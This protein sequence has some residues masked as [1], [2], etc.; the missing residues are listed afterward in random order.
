MSS[1][2]TTAGRRLIRRATSRVPY[3]AEWL[4]ARRLLALTGDFTAD[5]LFTA[6]DIDA[7]SAQVRA[8][9]NAV[10]FDLNADT[11][12][13]Q[14]DRRVWVEQIVG[15]KFGDAD[16]D[17][18]VDSA[19]GAI[20]QAN[21][22]QSN[23]GWAG[24]D[25][26][27]SGRVD[28]GDLSL[29]APNN[30]QSVIGGPLLANNAARLST[31]LIDVNGAIDDW[32]RLFN[33]TPIA[34][35][36]LPGVDDALA[37]VVGLV[38]ATANAAPTFNNPAGVVGT[39]QSRL[40]ALGFT[41]ITLPSTAGQSDIT[42]RLQKNFT[43]LTGARE[44]DDGTN[45]L[46]NGLSSALNLNGSIAHSVDFAVSMMLGVDAA[47]FYLRGD[48]T[49]TATVRG[50]GAV[51]GSYALPIATLGLNLAGTLDA[52]YTV[53]FTAGTPTAKIR[54]AQLVSNAWSR[55]QSGQGV[56]DLDLSLTRAGEPTTLAFDGTWSI[57]ITASAIGPATGG[58]VAP[59]LNEFVH[60]V[61]VL[62]DDGVSNLLPASLGTSLNGVRLPF[63]QG[64]PLASEFSEGA[65]RDDESPTWWDG[66]IESIRN[67]FAVPR[68][69]DYQGASFTS[70][71]TV[72]KVDKLRER[73]G[74]TGA[75]QKIGVISNGAVAIA[76]A[77][78]AKDL[79]S[80]VNVAPGFNLQGN[81]GIA[82]L[83]IV[84][85]LAPAAELYFGG[86]SGQASG[87]VA[88]HIAIAEWM[89]A[90]GVT[91]IV[92]DMGYFGEPFFQD[93]FLGATYAGLMNANPG[94]VFV[95]SAGNDALV[96]HQDTFSGAPLILQPSAATDPVTGV[97]LFPGAT[98]SAHRFQ[99]PALGAVPLVPINIP[100]GQTV[101]YLQWSDPIGAP[102]AGNAIVPYLVNP[103]TMQILAVGTPVPGRAEV[104]F[105]FNAAAAMQV[106]LVIVNSGGAI[107]P[108]VQF[109]MFL[110][111]A[112]RPG[113]GVHV[114]NGTG[115]NVAK[116]GDAVFSQ[117]GIDNVIATA[118]VRNG[119]LTQP[120]SYT[121]D[122]PTTVRNG[123]G[124]TT[125]SSVD[126]A[127]VDGIRV[128]G[129][130]GFSTPF[131]GTSSTSPQI[132][133]IV[134][135]LRE[136]KPTATRAELIQAIARG[137]SLFPVRNERLGMGLINAEVSGVFLAPAGSP[138]TL[139]SDGPE[140]ADGPVRG[141]DFLAARGIT[142]EQAPTVS[143]VLQLIAGQAPAGDF[144]RVRFD[145]ITSPT[146]T[147]LTADFGF[148]PASIAPGL[149]ISGA[150]HATMSP[151]ANLSLGI[152]AQG[153][154]L[155]GTSTFGATIAGTIDAT[156]SAGPFAIGA[157]GT[158]GLSPTIGFSTLGAGKLRLGAL[159]N[160]LNLSLQLGTVS[161]SFT[162]D[163]QLNHLDYVD[164]NPTI[165][166]GSHGGDPFVFRAT[167]GLTATQQNG[168]DFNYTF[169]PIRIQNPT[170]NG[171][172]YTYANFL[173]NIYRYGQDQLAGS[174]YLGR[175]LD[176]L[177]Q[178]V[179]P[180][181]D[182]VK[183]GDEIN[184][185]LIQLVLNASNVQ[186]LAP[187]SD[188]A[189]FNDLEA[190]L[191]TGGTSN[192][193]ILRARATI[194]NLDLVEVLTVG[195][196]LG[197]L[198]RNPSQPLNLSNALLNGTM[199]F[200]IDTAGGLFV[201][202]SNKTNLSVSVTATADLGN[203]GLL[204]PYGAGD[205][206][207]LDNGSTLTMNTT[208][209][210]LL[211][212][213]GKVRL[214]DFLAPI[215]N[216]NTSLDPIVVT[217]NSPGA[218]LLP[219]TGSSGYNARVNGITGSAVFNGTGLDLLTLNATSSQWNL[220]NEMRLSTGLATFTWDPQSPASQTLLSVPTST[221]TFPNR[222]GWPTGT[223]SNLQLTGNAITLGTLT[224]AGTDF[225]LGSVLEVRSPAFGLSGV[226]IAIAPSGVT[227][228]G[229]VSVSAASA[230]LF[231]NTSTLALDGLVTV[232]SPTLT[233]NGTGLRFTATNATFKV[234]SL[235]DITATGTLASPIIFNPDATGSARIMSLPSVSVS[236]PKLTIDGRTP[237][238]SFATNGTTPGL[239]L[240]GD[241]KWDVGSIGLGFSGGGTAT[242]GLGA[243]V[244]FE[245]G[246]LRIAFD[247]LPGGGANL[248]AFSAF[249]TGDVD[250]VALNALL[251][252]L[253]GP[254]VSAN[255]SILSPALT[256]GPEADVELKIRVDSLTGGR[257]GLQV[258]SLNVSIANAKVGVLD[259]SGNLG[260]TFSTTTGLPTSVTGGLGFVVGGASKVKKLSDADAAGFDAN[261]QGGASSVSGIEL[262]DGN[263]SFTG[264]VTNGTN[265]DLQVDSTV[266]V[267]FKLADFFDL[268]GVRFGFDFDIAGSTQATTFAPTITGGL[269]SMAVRKVRIK[270]GD[271]LVVTGGSAT[272]DAATLNFTGSGNIATFGPIAA[273]LP[274]IRGSTG[275]GLT[276]TVT[277]LAITQS[278]VPNL[279]PFPGVTDTATIGLTGLGQF[280][281]DNDNAVFSWLPITINALSVKFLPE[282]FSRDAQGNVTGLG[283]PAAFDLGVSGSIG[284]TIDLPGNNDP[285]LPFS[286]GVDG[287]VLDMLALYEIATT[288]STTRTIIKDLQGIS[289]GV[290]PFALLPADQSE[291]IPFTIGGSFGIGKTAN[292][293]FY[294]FVNGEFKYQ[295]F[296]GSV[297]LAISDR[298][299]LLASLSMPLAVPLGPTPFV[300]SGARGAIEWGIGS[301]ATPASPSEMLDSP[302]A[303]P[304]QIDTSNLAAVV[305]AKLASLAPGEFTWDQGVA[306]GLGGTITTAGVPD[307][308]AGNVDLA[309]NIGKPKGTPA[310]QFG[311]GVQVYGQGT[312]DAMGFPLAEAG[313]L[314]DFVNPIEPEVLLA[315]R[316][317]AA[318]NPL[319]F[320][321]PANA[322]FGVH[323]KTEGVVLAPIVA[324][325][326]FISNMT[327]SA[328][329]DLDAI[330]ARLEADR[331]NHAGNDRLLTTIVLDANND[332]TVS[333]AERSTPITR[334]LLVNRALSLLPATLTAAG[335]LSETAVRRAVRAFNG[336]QQ[337]YYA[338][339]ATSGPAFVGNFLQTLANS[340]QLAGLAA[341][342][343][344]NPTLSIRGKIQ[345]VVFGFPV[346]DALAEA[347]I[348]VSKQGVGFDVNANLTALLRK[349]ISQNNPALETMAYALSL[350]LDV[351]GQFGFYRDLTDE[352]SFLVNG[353]LGKK[354][355]PGAT[356][357][358]LG[359]YLVELLNPFDDWSVSFAGQVEFLGFPVGR[360]SGLF[361]GP[362]SQSPVTT[363][364]L[365]GGPG[366]PAKVYVADP[367]G[368]LAI[369]AYKDFT[370]IPV[371]SQSRIDNMAVTGGL[372][373]TGQLLAPA[374]IQ[375]PVGLITLINQQTGWTPP[376][377]TGNIGADVAAYQT[378]INGII[379]GL[380]TSDEF[381]RIQLFIPSPALLFDLDNLKG[382][383]AN[384]LKANYTTDPTID[385]AAGETLTLD[386]NGNGKFDQG[387]TF[388]DRGNGRFDAGE[389]VDIGNGIW[390]PGETLT[391]DRNGNGIFDP[392]DQFDDLN[393]N[394]TREANE[395]FVDLN[396]NGVF[397]AGDAFTDIGD[398]VI[399]PGESF[400]DTNNNG[401]YDPA[402]PFEDLNRNGVRDANEPFDD[403]NRNGVYDATGEPFVD[404]GN[405]VWDGP[406][407][408]ATARLPKQ[409]NA[410]TIST[411][412]AA[413][414]N[415]FFIEGYTDPKLFG[416][417][418]GRGK[419]SVDVTNGLRFQFQQTWLGV[420]VHINAGLGF[421][422]QDTTNL[423]DDLLTSPL[424]APLIG[425]TNVDTVRTFLTNNAASL[426][427]FIAF[428]V[429]F[430]QVD[431][432][433]AGL[434]Q[435]LN[436]VLKLPG[437][438]MSV[439]AAPGATFS[440]GFYTPGFKQPGGTA[441]PI[442]VYGGLSLDA[443]VNL[444]GLLED[445]QASF[446]MTFPAVKA[447]RAL[448]SL[449]DLLSAAVNA[450]PNFSASA[451][452]QRFA[453]S[454]AGATLVKITGASPA[455]P[456][457]FSVQKTGTNF[458]AN[459][460]GRVELLPD[461]SDFALLVNG[462][463]NADL[464]ASTPSFAA[465]LL[466]SAE[467][468]SDFV[469]PSIGLNLPRAGTTFRLVVAS[470]SAKPVLLRVDGELNA[471]GIYVAGQFDL[472]VDAVTTSLA[473]QAN[474]TVRATAG[475]G[476]GAPNLISLT[477][478]AG[479]RI[480][481]NG[482]AARGAM[483]LLAGA[484]PSL[485]LGFGFASNA[486]FE[487]NTFA[488]SQTIN[489]V[490][491]PAGRR[492]VA[493]DTDLQLGPFGFTAGA[494]I[495]VDPTSASLAIT[496]A[497]ENLPVFGT[498]V[499]NG[500]ITVTPTGFATNLS[501][502][503]TPAAGEVF[504][505]GGT[506]TLAVNTLGAVDTFAIAIASPTISLLG[507]DLALPSV[508]ITG[509]LTPTP[510]YTLAI[511]RSNEP[512]N[513]LGGLGI[514]FPS[515]TL[516][517]Y[518]IL[519]DSAGQFRID[520]GANGSYANATFSGWGVGDANVAR[521]SL[522]SVG[523]QVVRQAGTSVIRGRLKGSGMLAL[524]AVNQT[525]SLTSWLSF[526]DDFN[527]AAE[528]TDAA[529]GAN[530]FGIYVD[531]E[532]P[533]FDQLFSGDLW[534]R[535]NIAQS[536][537]EMTALDPFAQPA[538]P[539]RVDVSSTYIGTG[540]WASDSP[541]LGTYDYTGGTTLK[542]A[543]SIPEQNDALK[544][545]A[546][547]L[548]AGQSITVGYTITFPDGPLIY[549]ANRADVASALT[550][551]FSLTSAIPTFNLATI[552]DDRYFEFNEKVL[553]TLTYT[554]VGFSAA[555]LIKTTN[556]VEYT[557]VNA[558]PELDR[559]LAYWEFD[560]GTN[561]TG[562]YTG[563]P[564]F[565]A[566]PNVTVT[567]WRHTS[568]N[569]FTT[570]P[571][572]PGAPGGPKSLDFEASEIDSVTVGD[573]PTFSTSDDITVEAW[574][575]PESLSGIDYFLVAGP[576]AM[577]VNGATNKF[578]V[579]VLPSTGLPSG[580]EFGTATINAWT[581]VAAS[582]NS[583]ALKVYV[584][585]V[586]VIT[587]TL[588]FTQLSTAK[589]V[590]F[591]TDT[592][593]G[594]TTDYYDGRLDEV[595]IWNIERTAIQIAADDTNAISPL[596]SGLVGYWQFDQ[597][598]D[599]IAIYDV[600]G[601]YPAAMRQTGPSFAPALSTTV[602]PITYVGSTP[603]AAG[604]NGGLPQIQP[605]T[606]PQGTDT[607]AVTSTRWG[608]NL[609]RT[610][611][612][613][614]FDRNSGNTVDDLS[615]FNSDATLVQPSLTNSQY[616]SGVHGQAIRFAPNAVGVKNGFNPVRAPLN[617]NTM[618][619]AA[620]D[621]SVSFWARNNTFAP[622]T[623]AQ[624]AVFFYY[625]IGSVRLSA[626]TDDVTGGL[627]VEYS[628][629]TNTTYTVPLSDLAGNTW[630]HF[631]IEVDGG[632]GALG[633]L[634]VWVDGV[635][636]SDSNAIGTSG[637]LSSVAQM[638]IGGLVTAEP[639]DFANVMTGA[640]D[641]FA[642]L[643]GTRQA[644]S[645][646]NTDDVLNMKDFDVGWALQ[647]LNGYQFQVGFT[648]GAATNLRLRLDA[649]RFF[650]FADT[651]GGPT[652][653]LLV[654]SDAAN[655]NTV[656]ARV[657]GNT[658]RGEWGGQYAELRNK[659]FSVRGPVQF[660]LYGIG[661][662]TGNWRIEN[663]NLEGVVLN[664]TAAPTI[665]ANDDRIDARGNGSTTFNILANDTAP[666]GTVIDPQSSL[667]GLPT[668]V[669][670]TVVG[671]TSIQFTV[672]SAYA[673]EFELPY[674]IR[675]ASGNESGA[676]MRVRVPELPV[677]ETEKVSVARGQ[678]VLLP[679]L[680]ND[681]DGVGAGLTLSIVSAPPTSTVG[682]LS[683]SGGQLRLIALSTATTG[684]YT[685]I[686]RI[687]DAHGRSATVQDDLTITANGALEAVRVNVVPVIVGTPSATNSTSLPTALAG[688][689]VGQ[690]FFVELWAQDLVDR[691]GISGGSIDLSY[692]TTIADAVALQRPEF[693]FAPVGS[694][695]DPS[696][697]VD[698]FGGGSL[699][700]G[701]GASPAFVRL[702]FVQF[703]ATGAGTFNVSLAPGSFEFALFGLGNVPFTDVTLGT[704]PS[705]TINTGA[706]P[707]APQLAS[708]Q[709]TGV[710]GSDGITR[711]NRPIFAGSAGTSGQTIELL[712]NGNVVGTATIG[713]GG[714]YTVQPTAV[715]VDGSYAMAVRIGTSTS[716]TT[717]IQIDNV[718]PAVNAPVWNVNLSPHVINWTSTESL[719]GT[720][721]LA[722]VTLTN[723]S[724]A[725]NVAAGSML[726]TNGTPT[727]FALTFPGLAA[728]RLAEGRYLLAIPSA[729][730]TDVAGNTLAAP[731]SFQFTFRPG[732]ATG[733][734]A[735]N[736]ND[737][738]QLAAN[739]NQSG[740]SF[741]QG[742]FNY[743][744]TVNFDDLLILASRYNQPLAGAP[745]GLAAGGADDD[746]SNGGA[747]NADVL[748]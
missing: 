439:P 100:A 80:V 38:G 158:I 637:P 81:E 458:T 623:A 483:S 602:P 35:K 5:R 524:P 288:G 467:S 274:Q 446:E 512:Q 475:T 737:L 536:W 419:L 155:S 23:I 667:A 674:I 8:G 314:F 9:T 734:G 689:T 673:G 635:I 346:G 648:A 236:V 415:A 157:S 562:G 699:S 364:L 591:G 107:A 567:D 336:F 459:L 70:A 437:S 598:D 433:T 276:G 124:F 385:N 246:S 140:A 238:L 277:G 119:A 360:I 304:T 700:G 682:T 170:F 365:R 52:D 541:D 90:Q 686:Y 68:A 478:S 187:A 731:V 64:G 204:G 472:S 411:A 434:T 704:T 176:A 629:G 701:L 65:R 732:D 655:V 727:G 482:V 557:I 561:A 217:L 355:N 136:L 660:T 161:A 696:G 445:A 746:D 106:G 705:L 457:G 492:R 517:S 150:V 378:W 333:A 383:N 233:L 18:D 470:A 454:L 547:G 542:Q 180:L 287:L 401:K 521:L 490:S 730:V 48:S 601:R 719:G 573:G 222:P 324:V 442:E 320:L 16:L 313:L 644:S 69:T 281:S 209:R 129:Y 97:P 606:V 697:I 156:A 330:A 190:W 525:Y 325:R 212:G 636:R 460:N 630:H 580:V 279:L 7:L 280:F 328:V 515:M 666:A 702:G 393:R 404:R 584:N 410:A 191:N 632:S 183:V 390:D 29:L 588:S 657:H 526:G 137:G 11:L 615:P 291:N 10:A 708:G 416:L 677:A 432:S 509:V 195:G 707:A 135:L 743:D 599:V 508:S 466:L 243:L 213:T 153:F 747:R 681:F 586:N 265:F 109:E 597:N 374:I 583:G 724:T 203:D 348:T 94:V 126:I 76:D 369:D 477:G 638:T 384:Y 506:F 359:G 111:N 88:A 240:R 426:P 316:S 647:T 37:D 54:P 239:A 414:G 241:G 407:V 367:F 332:G 58:V 528:A 665:Q 206:M 201:D 723:Q 28:F 604:T 651:T 649:L 59:S 742:D 463:V 27:G 312:I 337:E 587:T 257:I 529:N 406:A 321:L 728:A 703:T 230:A 349:M 642:I 72:L 125:R 739:Y 160:P 228:L 306:M 594:P 448:N 329:A 315:F 622:T 688:A 224:V 564:T 220:F 387:D 603:A 331:L 197:E 251:A 625:D 578:G 91:V 610:R 309:I 22:G 356:A 656:Y 46:L 159:T 307:G 471:S 40:A 380:T 25:F 690:T 132:G 134:A 546:S 26:D 427:R 408:N 405:G 163:L 1:K 398:G 533:I 716:T 267:R 469:V 127:G 205:F 618:P 436:S 50:D 256:N 338:I 43:A 468:G 327:T 422:N 464:S 181:S 491:I 120:A 498:F 593:G 101:T 465:N 661:G 295:D 441:K 82:M 51:S 430:A 736:F 476:A 711:L 165:P 112:W 286:A 73:F 227:A 634:R 581:H 388:T 504:S 377:I 664:A 627:I 545:R 79:P 537:A 520:G 247:T 720:L 679:V 130:G 576:L 223:L 389:T 691:V 361:F 563:S 133:A 589:T 402:D 264:T 399:T 513:P 199:E 341:L 305:Q 687:T 519:I 102:V 179:Q 292:G 145:R 744:G 579:I 290:D 168:F 184:E 259:L 741:T 231:P 493:F 194:T 653:W 712:A 596:T 394:G 668:G 252:P 85:D 605:E 693:G 461:V 237:Q 449:N 44:F 56:V 45:P 110:P 680:L 303:V 523:L 540:S 444:P 319:G 55:T 571:G 443:K 503:R 122:G 565:V 685:F 494:V 624:E 715:L 353:L 658:T 36:T 99:D 211:G 709:D 2:I 6:A 104:R 552:L 626:S 263:L 614:P 376:A 113:G 67:T 342:D 118:A 202:R 621:F 400:T 645:E 522:N 403:Q 171:G 428:P 538:E 226:S 234:G 219:R 284:G 650:D 676:T 175:L 518:R 366:V 391:L 694:I 75:G 616:I 114:L 326:E 89:I 151:R 670:A 340:A 417:D 42:V 144:L 350:G 188:Q 566:N 706:T 242:F 569:P 429:G 93:G 253:F 149:N 148:D 117:P 531:L 379:T 60:Q 152:D 595:R 544:F 592:P 347:T 225:T 496:A 142:V 300:L 71:D 574:V 108:G 344:F 738:L 590:L 418:L 539:K 53:T 397:D 95:S 47:G 78:A 271:F 92:D 613:F 103:A 733:D 248:D 167:A 631:Y 608:S 713:T 258:N 372:L 480:A 358:D 15:A 166:N 189:F 412:L 317:P 435:F 382:A 371:S 19:D 198:L 154:F 255:V 373:L 695:N 575:R 3:V 262:N 423:F 368:P 456:F 245:V 147:P 301:L 31:G 250:E 662:T 440:L 32:A 558:D 282:I 451:T 396:G 141:L 216:V 641:D 714:A 550:G 424:I 289:G 62:L 77:I 395:P 146:D 514:G 21:F 612:Y 24:G 643:Q 235:V 640:I 413:I 269:R 568:E 162:A 4:E 421:Q 481:P 646:Y 14:A 462:A 177:D 672:D 193:E 633:I 500:T 551:S 30:G 488:T 381:A 86:V 208:A 20:V 261:Q 343:Q 654:V 96:H 273:E 84:H 172:N 710:S 66:A 425:S 214:R 572:T 617:D 105:V 671:G 450:F 535:S 12:V 556:T 487:I 549:E 431:I 215:S 296:G 692:T 607:D 619:Q 210:V 527:F 718:A 560:T 585:G 334:T 570:T 323:L 182:N 254:T 229:G 138:A 453:P 484:N 17:G 33:L 740:R 600:T 345:P 497:T 293:A 98:V 516:T 499:F 683:V 268:Y 532:R 322:E 553:V 447:D 74:L 717:V 41:L 185:D 474:V 335:G 123:S 178:L 678:N 283:N 186:V 218:D 115:F 409:T 684:S 164:N 620:D 196:S 639:A 628:Q 485:G 748:L 543:I 311:I 34:G 173:T 266:G 745:A 297:T 510:L 143:T 659:V 669:I 420:S 318:G 495:Q 486:A 354:P 507:L 652:E 49:L 63:T 473:T 87:G 39:L 534:S 479:L 232:T 357:N 139:R 308:L 721:T 294:L 452:A 299:P 352:W 392:A 298:G 530:K 663:V 270:L 302:P 362:E 370:R 502:A 675:D 121:S 725:S 169:S 272:Q 339:H 698:D 278:G 13:N 729:G 577:F 174:G 200:G 116:P 455:Q 351:R 57:P 438:I 260:I 275:P 310:G 386:R 192:F 582:F 555:S 249:L 285:V 131:S 489:A 735:V 505:L 611:L 548:A 609:N 722:D 244:P 726:L 363:T 61:L 128:G 554:P 501:L 83:E 559:S 221:V 207:R 375:D 511:S